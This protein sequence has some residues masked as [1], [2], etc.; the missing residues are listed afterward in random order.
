MREIEYKEATTN[1]TIS[2]NVLFLCSEQASLSTEVIWDFEASKHVND[3]LRIF[4]YALLVICIISLGISN[5][6]PISIM[7]CF[8][9]FP[10]VTTF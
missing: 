4:Y 9:M 1:I 8:Q 3:V 10:N 7:K 6:C 2:V 5:P